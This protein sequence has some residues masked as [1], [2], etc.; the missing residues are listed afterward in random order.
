MLTDLL[1]T[2]DCSILIAASTGTATRREVRYVPPA[3]KQHFAVSEKRQCPEIWQN[4]LF[5]P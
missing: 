4:R 3:K 2:V 1:N 5:S